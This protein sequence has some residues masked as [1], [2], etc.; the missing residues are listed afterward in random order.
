MSLNLEE[1]ELL[2]EN[3]TLP[4]PFRPL[5]DPLV[6]IVQT[7]GK[8]SVPRPSSW[9]QDERTAGC[10]RMETGWF[11]IRSE[12]R[13]WRVRS[14]CC[15]CVS[16]VRVRGSRIR[17]HGSGYGSTGPRRAALRAALVSREMLCCDCVVATCRWC[18]PAESTAFNRLRLRLFKVTLTL[19]FH[20]DSDSGFSKS[21][22][23]SGISKVTRT[24]AFQK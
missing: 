1:I 14:R 18:R 5:L 9:S 16:R 15:G 10:I 12:T 11:R 3:E 6:S 13:T 8:P 20:S 19:A 2:R 23:D 21:D 24:P 22:S 7:L 4:L 17:V